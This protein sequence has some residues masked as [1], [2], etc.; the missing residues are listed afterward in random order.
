MKKAQ[1][2]GNMWYVCVNLQDKVKKEEQRKSTE[3]EVQRRLDA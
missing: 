1:E 3:F 2:V